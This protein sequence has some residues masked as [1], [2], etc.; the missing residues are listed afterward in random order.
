MDCEDRELVDS[1]LEESTELLEKI[2]EDLLSLEKSP[3]DTELLHRIFRSIHTVK[4]AAGFL[5]FELLVRVTHQTEDVLNRLR[6]G[7]MTMSQRIM[8][9][10]LEA[11]ELVK[12]LVNDIKAGAAVE[13]P[14][15]GTIARLVAV[16]S[17][18]CGKECPAQPLVPDRDSQSNGVLCSSTREEPGEAVAVPAPLEAGELSSPPNAKGEEPDK[19]TVRVDVKRID[20]L[21]DQV[22]E[23]VL[24]RNRMIQLNNDFRDSRN[25]E[26]F[27]EEFAKLAKR[28]NFVTSELQMQAMKMRLIPVS[29]VFKKFPRI[30]RNMARDLGKE[31]ELQVFGEETELDRSVVNEIGDPLIHLLRNAMDHGLERPEE[32]CAAGKDATGTIVLSARHEG[33]HIII[34]IKDDGRGL[35]AEKIAAKAIEKGLLTEEQRVGLTQREIFDFIFLPG[36]STRESA[37]D[38][39]GR[40]VGMDVVRTNIRNLNGIITTSSEIGKGTEFTLAL[41][42]TLAIIQSLLVEVEDETYSIPLSAVLETLRVQKSEIR[43][44]GGRKVLQLRD[45]VLPLLGLDEM[46][47]AKR[48]GKS[49]KYSYVVV[50]GLAEKRLGLVVTK[51]L[52]QQEVAI[53]TLGKYL[54]GVQGIAGST[55]LGDGRVA[56]IVDPAKIIDWGEGIGKHVLAFSD[57]A[58]SAQTLP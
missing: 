36:F 37:S 17:V 26:L 27:A 46:F 51:L 23:L 33:S 7:E 50:V 39:S 56:L 19:T 40:G 6:K 57:A 54:S 41:P 52:G 53:K 2:D 58:S 25:M 8:D 28:V 47:A 9:V 35:D 29:N 32:R 34:S 22:G 31:V 24:E 43:T 21:M 48:H 11:L 10:I 18:D 20:D 14:I 13:R 44:I 42:L 30:I 49:H 45:M 16:L 3:E 55:I 1:F 12:E 38:F 5:E 15:E 4:G